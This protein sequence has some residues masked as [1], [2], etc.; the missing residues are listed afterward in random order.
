MASR[1]NFLGQVMSESVWCRDCG[2]YKVFDDDTSLCW[3]CHKD[4][5]RQLAEEVEERRQEFLLNLHDA[6]AEDRGYG[7]VQQERAEREW[8]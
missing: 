1:I 6:A 4:A 7:K 3:R 8:K 2:E 5:E